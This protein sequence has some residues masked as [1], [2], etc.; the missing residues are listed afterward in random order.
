MENTEKENSQVEEV[1]AMES[2]DV[3]QPAMLE[4][5]NRSEI[6]MQISTA[7]KYPRDISKVLNKIESYATIDKETAAS[8][9]YTLK[10][11]NEKIEGLSTRFAEIIANAWGNIRV[12]TR[13]IGNDGRFV[14]SQGVCHDLESN[15]AVSVEVMRRITDKYGKTYSEDMQVTTSNAAS[16]IAFRNAVLKVIPKA[17]TAKIVN[18]VKEVAKG[19][20]K[21]LETRRTSMIEIFKKLNVSEKQILDYLEISKIE[22]IDIDML[23]EM[24]GI[25][26]AIKEGQTTI[27]ETFVERQ[28]VGF[29]EESQ[30]DNKPANDVK[31]GDNK[32]DKETNKEDKETPNNS[33]KTAN[34]GLF[35]DKKDQTQ[36]RNINF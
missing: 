6:D 36:S 15:I 34:D 21:D 2:I 33:T 20:T 14:T 27:E 4:A 3:L 17:I 5:I 32:E 9:F 7:K 28:T 26:N 30:E 10:R 31:N 22:E 19:S 1:E 23:F 24:G 35:D 25:Y 29:E 16:A 18:K 8:C 13:I 11:K 12:Q